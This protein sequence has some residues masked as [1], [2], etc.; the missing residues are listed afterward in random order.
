MGIRVPQIS[1]FAAPFGI[2]LHNLPIKILGQIM[3]YG[4]G[5][6]GAWRRE[7]GWKLRAK[8]RVQVSQSEDEGKRGTQ[9]P[10][11]THTLLQSELLWR[12]HKDVRVT[13]PR[14]CFSPL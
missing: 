12:K 14:P 11:P 1:I 3:D 7:K 2:V 10:G 9:A 6:G 5:A 4:G 8:E 13:S